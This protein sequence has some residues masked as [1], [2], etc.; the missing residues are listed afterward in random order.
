MG[1]A[2]EWESTISGGRYTFSYEKIKRKHTLTVNGVP[3]V[4]KVG[5]LSA[6]LGI[7][8]KFDLNGREAR[9]VMVRGKPDVVVDD[10]HLQ[11]GKPYVKRPTWAIVFAFICLAI[12]VV[13][14]G[15]ALPILLGLGGASLCIMVAKS[16]L[17]LAVRVML[18]VI[19]TIAAWVLLFV[20]LALVLLL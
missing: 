18:A 3:H 15:G 1:K 4:I 17:P 20:L 14:L 5:F 12:P 7:D 10:V 2:I 16:T 6:M 13:S 9:F 11:S 19:I 8:E